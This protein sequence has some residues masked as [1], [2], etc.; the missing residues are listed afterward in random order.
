MRRR[1]KS[2]KAQPFAKPHTHRHTNIRTHTHTK[3]HKHTHTH[4]HTNRH[5][6]T[7]THKHTDTNTQTATGTHSPTCLSLVSEAERQSIGGAAF[8]GC[9]TS[10]PLMR[11]GASR[12][13]WS[14]TY[15]DSRT[16]VCHGQRGEG[17]G[18]RG[19]GG[20]GVR[21]GEV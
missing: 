11:H 7:D 3:T 19:E 1:R 14:S 17:G 4:T 16:P 18:G 20:R 6:N 12:V 9:A 8:C 13:I 5:I 10:T 2:V 15:S 21:E